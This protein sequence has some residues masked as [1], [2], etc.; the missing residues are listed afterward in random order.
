MFFLLKET[1]NMS[2]NFLNQLPSP[3]EIKKELKFILVDRYND[4]YRD[5]FQRFKR[6]NQVDDDLIPLP[7]D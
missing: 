7:L 2:F 6:K 3:E 5:L 1:K 4:I